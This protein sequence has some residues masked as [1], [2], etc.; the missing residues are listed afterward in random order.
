MIVDCSV[1]GVVV[2]DY[3][4]PGLVGLIDYPSSAYLDQFYPVPQIP[5]SQFG[6]PAPRCRSAACTTPDW[7]NPRLPRVPSCP[8]LARSSRVARPVA[9][10]CRSQVRVSA[11]RPPRPRPVLQFPADYP[12]C[13]PFCP[14]PDQDSDQSTQLI[15]VGLIRVDHPDHVPSQPS[16]SFPD[17]QFVPSSDCPDV[18]SCS[19]P[20]RPAQ[21]FGPRRSQV[22]RAFTYVPRTFTYAFSPSSSFGLPRPRCRAP[23]PSRSQFPARAP[24]ATAP[25][26]ATR[27]RSAVPRLRAFAAR[28]HAHAQYAFPDYRP[29]FFVEFGSPSAR[30]A[31]PPRP[32]SQ[33]P[34]SLPTRGPDPV[35][36]APTFPFLPSPS[37][38][39]ARARTQPSTTTH[40]TPDPDVHAPSSQIAVASST[41]RPFPFCSYAPARS[42]RAPPAPSFPRAPRPA[43]RPVAYLPR[44]CSFPSDPGC[45]RARGA[46]R[47]AARRARVARPAFR[48]GRRPFTFA[49]YPHPSY[50]LHYYL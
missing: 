48:A 33:F 37:F 43:F 45:L 47:I 12:A 30:L 39:R 13:R 41:C 22:Q 35:P 23:V 16:D 40:P 20:V 44:T 18:P 4:P 34:S 25:R 14:R 11:P 9:R 32:S 46:L 27:L 15:P 19:Y 49:H 26:L 29:S 6:L 5:S 28:S 38:P 7:I 21:P 1:V 10:A 2:V 50:D 24:V 42:T 17:S 3:R 36:A 8:S 31:A